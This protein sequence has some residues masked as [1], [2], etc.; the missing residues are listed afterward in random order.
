MIAAALWSGLGVW[1]W[2]VV[3]ALLVGLVAAGW[4]VHHNIEQA[5]YARAQAEYQAAAELQR[6]GNRG[7]ARDAEQKQAAQT[8]YR[9]RFITQTVKEIQY[10]TANLAACVLSPGAVGMLNDAAR[11]AGEDRP[12]A[13]GAGDGLPAPG[14]PA[15]AGDRAGPGQLDY[16]MDRG[17]RLRAQ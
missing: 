17:L 10:V 6:E 11:C 1:R 16:R 8:V 3:G 14:G 7:R 12:A 2:A 15:R 9:D 13:C 4:R 5:G